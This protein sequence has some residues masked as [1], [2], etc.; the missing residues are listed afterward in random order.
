MFEH[1]VHRIFSLGLHD[2]GNKTGSN[3]AA[4]VSSPTMTGTSECQ[5]LESLDGS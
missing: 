1:N 2:D 5:C 3:D 4:A